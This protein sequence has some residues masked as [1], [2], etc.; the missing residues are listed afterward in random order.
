MLK[1]AGQQKKR[2]KK[3]NRRE[4]AFQIKLVEDLRT[5]LPRHVIVVHVPNGGFRS[6]V[7]AGILKAM[8]VLKGFPDLL[9]LFNS[10]AFTIE[11]KLDGTAANDEQEL[12]HTLLRGT[13]IPVAVC[14]SLDEVLG[15][16]TAWNI[17]TRIIEGAKT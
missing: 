7:E 9:I 3:Q 2:R 5:I 10:R 4:Q 17:P 14:R 8:G 13:H 16:L 1:G 12:C 6:K 11:L 15:R